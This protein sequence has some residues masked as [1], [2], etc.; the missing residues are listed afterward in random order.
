MLSRARS[1]GNPL[2]DGDSVTFVW[3]GDDPPLLAGDFNHWGRAGYPMNVREVSPGMWA[4][5]LKLPRGVYIEYDF[6][7]DG[8]H[9]GDPH[10]PHLVDSGVGHM[11]HCF[12]MPDYAHTD[13]TDPQPDVE[14]GKIST[15][16]LKAGPLAVGGRRK[17]HFYSPPIDQ[18][19]PLLVV[20]D[21]NDYLDRG[22]LLTIADNLI[23]QGRIRPLALALIDNHP[24]ERMIEYACSELTVGLVVGPL[25][26]AASA[27]L[28][29]LDIEYHPRAYGVLGAS[30][31]G[32]MAL[33]TALR[34]PAIFG[35]VISQS[36]AFALD[37]ND[38]VVFS[39]VEHGPVRPVQIWMDV[40][41]FDFPDL[42]EANPRMR[43]LLLS[44]G[45]QMSYREYPGGHN[46][47]AWRDDVW[48]G[49]E[50]LFPAEIRG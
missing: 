13:L 18:P 36:G 2:I 28:N 47:T 12:A 4:Y 5:A 21:G 34:A 23:A 17:V 25:L 49:L 48:R 1:E 29:L 32:L 3:E 31:G 19:C 16:T 22:H 35:K 30:M 37:R 6:M 44:R 43:D 7:R 38:T 26:E 39:L 24:R 14:H 8:K 45:Y 50:S 9:L 46:Y 10:N 41:R 11:Q 15:L 40:G 33:Y 42:C 20:Y 27:H